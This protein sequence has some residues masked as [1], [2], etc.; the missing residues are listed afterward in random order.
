M[1][2]EVRDTSYWKKGGLAS[3]SFSQ[4]SLTNWSGGGDNNVALNAL[5]N[6]F[7]NYEKRKISWENNLK[8]EY[9]LVKQGDESLRKSID[10]IDFATKLG[11]KNGGHW[12]YS[13]LAQ[14]QTQFDKGYNYPNDV[15]VVSRFLAPA[16]I[17]T[18]LGMDYKPNDYFSAYL[19]PLTGK[20]TIVNDD[21]LSEMGAF[22]VDAGD[23]FRAEFGA[24]T[25]LSF[26]KDV[27]ENV[28]LQTV[29]DLF[30]NYSENFGNIDINWE[31]LFTMK[32]NK[33]LTANVS[34]T[35]KYDDDVDYINKDGVNKGPR[36]QFKEIIG[37]G[38]AY[39]F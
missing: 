7:A 29:L 36:I 16:Y 17:T 28:N 2:Q 35:L 33:F 27:W 13:A 10:N 18:S 38:L 30:S 12:Y 39:K 22:G 15:D 14:F 23:K 31:V 19:S 6:L 21:D 9:G 4:T 3:V 20:M 25:K 1:A 8:M 5:L 32:V 11:I 37:I 26:H 34:T 24:F